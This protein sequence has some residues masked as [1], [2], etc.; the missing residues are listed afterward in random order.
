M[1][2]ARARF[3]YNQFEAIMRHEVPFR[4]A[5][6][7]VVPKCIVTKQCRRLMHDHH[8][9]HSYSTEAEAA[10]MRHEK[11]RGIEPAKGEAGEGEGTDGVQL[12]SVITNNPAAETKD[13]GEEK[14]DGGDGRTVG[15]HER[16]VGS[17]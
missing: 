5:F 14:G 16:V 1:E 2:T 11:A 13:A 3:C 6:L 15:A 4:E 9:H 17:V 10:T 12:V 7:S 8:R